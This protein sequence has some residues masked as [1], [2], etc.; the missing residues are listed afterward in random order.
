VA[1][2][3]RETDSIMKAFIT[4]YALT[5][6]IMEVNDAT[7]EGGRT[8]MMRGNAISSHLKAVKELEDMK[9]DL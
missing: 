5:K 6:G 7:E 4:K 3:E 2:I 8:E 1:G 9:F